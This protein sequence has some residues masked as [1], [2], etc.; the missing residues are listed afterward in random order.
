LNTIPNAVSNTVNSIYSIE[1]GP[2]LKAKLFEVTQ[3]IPPIK[4]D[5]KPAKDAYPEPFMSNP[6]YHITLPEDLS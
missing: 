1:Q 5:P 3:E 2:P 4:W 6:Q